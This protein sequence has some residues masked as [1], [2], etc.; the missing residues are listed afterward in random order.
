MFLLDTNVVSE[1]RKPKPHAGVMNWLGAQEAAAL[2]VSAM[3][4]GEL[5]RV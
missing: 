3:T 2:Y 4:I 1:T 5:Q